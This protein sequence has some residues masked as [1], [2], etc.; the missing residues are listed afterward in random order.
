M[1]ITTQVSGPAV[2]AV[3]EDKLGERVQKSFQT[4]LEE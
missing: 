3:V 1:D 2:G 4:F